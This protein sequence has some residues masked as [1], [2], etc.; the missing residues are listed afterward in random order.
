MK[1][2][3]IQLSVIAL[4]V[5]SVPVALQAEEIVLTMAGWG[6]APDIEGFEKLFPG[7]KIEYQR[8]PG[9][10]SYIEQTAVWA[11]G[12]T[13]PDILLIP[14]WGI[15]TM[16]ENGI[17]RDISDL[18]A[19]D[20]EYMRGFFPGS[21]EAFERKG[22]LYGVPWLV[23][24]MSIVYNPD[25]FAHG[26][27]ADPLVLAQSNAWNMDALVES[28]RK[29]TRHSENQMYERVG[30]YSNTNQLHFIA[31]MVWALDGDIIG[32]DGETVLVDQ[33]NS[34]LALERL[35]DLYSH[36]NVFLSRQQLGQYNLD[37]NQVQHG[38]HTAMRLTWNV[39]YA[40]VRENGVSADIAPVP[41]SMTGQPTDLII[42]HGIGISSQTEHPELAWEYIKYALRET[43]QNLEIPA[44]QEHFGPWAEYH[45]YES[46]WDAFQY[47]SLITNSIRLAP[48]PLNRDIEL[49][50]VR[51]LDQA[52]RG[53]KAVN[54]AVEEIRRQVE[55]RLQQMR[56]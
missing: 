29:L 7:V 11:L 54:A 35:A 44:R 22:G 5:V 42:V 16:A 34:V 39:E 18:A 43:P 41:K 50:F 13:L 25:L 17:L 6:G 49:V 37:V 38:P 1:R 4:L 55:A 8:V 9:S 46:D 26:G 53:Q 10:Y 51:N 15:P 52:L 56:R 23:G 48:N 28:A 40:Y 14:Y 30:F 20:P 47:L 33:Q 19:N 21:L 36:E 45:R 2:R 32:D 31:P 24:P 27:L 12:G 3:L